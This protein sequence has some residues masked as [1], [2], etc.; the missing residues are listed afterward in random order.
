[1][2]PTFRKGGYQRRLTTGQEKFDKMCKDMDLIV[3]KMAEKLAEIRL[4]REGSK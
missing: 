4:L 2:Y 3:A 1:M